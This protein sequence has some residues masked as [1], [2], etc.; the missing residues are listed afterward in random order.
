MHRPFIVWTAVIAA[1]ALD[2]GAIVDYE[3]S[4]ESL[5]LL[6]RVLAHGALILNPP[7]KGSSDSL[8]ITA[9]RRCRPRLPT[10]AI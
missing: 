10:K 6:N 5:D 8:T 9:A 7:R 2:L 1:V 3:V 4:A